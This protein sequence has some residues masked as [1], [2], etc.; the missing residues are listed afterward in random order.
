MESESEKSENENIK[1]IE[2]KVISTVN[3]E[4]IAESTNKRISRWYLTFPKCELPPDN[5]LKKLEEIIKKKK[6]NYIKEYV[7]AQES[8]KDKTLHLHAYILTLKKI[9][10]NKNLWDIITPLKIYHGNYQ[11]CINKNKTIN[12]I[13]KGNNFITNIPNIEKYKEIITTTSKNYLEYNN[14]ILNND[15]TKLIDNGEKSISNLSTLYKNKNLYFTLKKSMEIFQI[16][17]SFWIYG[18]SRIGKSYAVRMAFPNIFPK[19]RS[20]WWDGYNFQSEILFEDF[21]KTTKELGGEL[22]IWTDQYIFQGE[23]KGGYCQPIYDIFIITSN[24]HIDDIWSP[25]DD[26]DMNIAIYKRF[27]I[28][29]YKNRNQYDEIIKTL[30][31]GKKEII[32]FKNNNNIIKSENKND[33][34]NEKS[35]NGKSEN[36]NENENDNN[37]E[38]NNNN[39]IINPNN[40]NGNDNVNTN[41]DND[42]TNVITN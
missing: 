3:N 29:E 34:D 21:D 11:K 28:I 35:E 41:N 42:N 37:S 38:N 6:G 26:I 1:E 31:N 5:C 24:Y 15:L 2:V 40:D 7:I 30:Q 12:Y 4:T 39:N 23:I 17:K 18:E 8:H 9:L 10:W 36:D 14:S 27:T 22:K 16:R 25:N 13:I 20:K 19:P 32:N 33:N